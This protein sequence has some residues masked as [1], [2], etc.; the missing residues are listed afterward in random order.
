ME[1]LLYWAPPWLVRGPQLDVEERVRGLAAL[2]LR[3]RGG[4]LYLAI[5]VESRG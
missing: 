2:D 3:P 4:F 5:G 1:I